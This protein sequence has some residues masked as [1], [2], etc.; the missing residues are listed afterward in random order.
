LRT[1]TEKKLPKRGGITNANRTNPS[2]S[3]LPGK[4]KRLQSLFPPSSTQKKN[5][6]LQSLLIP[7]KAAT[8]SK[9]VGAQISEVKELANAAGGAATTT[10][11]TT[12]T[13]LGYGRQNSV[14][15]RG[16]G[17]KDRPVQEAHTRV[18]DAV[19]AQICKSEQIPIKRRVTAA[20]Q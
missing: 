2:H 16:R 8:A 6:S 17:T 9:Q 5:V 18:A 15:E 20:P 4:K 10:T 19:K 1:T 12:T 11:T 14:G 3:T 7:A 13:T